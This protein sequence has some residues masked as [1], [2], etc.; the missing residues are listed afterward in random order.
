MLTNARLTA[1]AADDPE[2]AQEA[3]RQVYGAMYRYALGH[4]TEQ[5]RSRLLSILRP[6]CPEVFCSQFARDDPY[7]VAGSL[8][9]V[10]TFAEDTALETA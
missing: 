9:A 4:I 7:A 2:R 8:D 10:E 5:E 1:A 3:R 6:C